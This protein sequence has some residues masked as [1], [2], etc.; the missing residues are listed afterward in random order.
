MRTTAKSALGKKAM[1]KKSR[2]T[3]GDYGVSNGE[4]RSITISSGDI[5]A[6]GDGVAVSR[7]ISHSH[8]SATSTTV[9]KG[10]IPKGVK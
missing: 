2:K 10:T 5:V 1:V 9:G 6:N 3:K 4:S 8:T 7:S